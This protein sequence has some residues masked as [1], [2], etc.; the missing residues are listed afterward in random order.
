MDKI[1]VVYGNSLTINKSNYENEK[2]LYSLKSYAEAGKE[3][4]E[5]ERL[6]SLVD[7]LVKAH[8]DRSRLDISKLRVRIKD[9]KK[10]PSVNSILSPDPIPM[11]PALLQCYADRGTEIEKMVFDFIETGVWREPE[12]SIG[13]LKWSDI[14][15]K[16]FFDKYGKIL[17][18]KNMQKKLEVFNEARMYSGEIDV[19]C[20]VE[21]MTVLSDW[22]TGQWKWEQVVAYGQ[23]HQADG[24]EGYAIFDLKKC[25]IEVLTLHEAI[26]YWEN[27]LEKRGAFRER[28]GV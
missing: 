8:Y 4:E 2:P 6:K 18:F 20:E 7:P 25:K 1:E 26:P 13:N 23:C 27:F 12:V 21:G 5:F 22:K 10:Y 28:F 14:K 17:N 16:E 3:A 19:I 15:Y 24:I 9:G 11:D